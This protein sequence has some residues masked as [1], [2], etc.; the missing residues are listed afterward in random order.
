MQA[1]TLAWVSL[2]ATKMAGRNAFIPHARTSLFFG[3][4]ALSGL[5]GAGDICCRILF[6]QLA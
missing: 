2:S 6:I 5:P 1:K 3:S 4:L